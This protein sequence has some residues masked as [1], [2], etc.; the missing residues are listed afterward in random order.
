MIFNAVGAVLSIFFMI[1]IGIFVYWRK[2][3]NRKEASVFAK[4]VI[5]VALPANVIYSFLTKFNK[6]LIL[7][8]GIYLLV[9]VI[10]LIIT[11]L[12]GYGISVLLKVDKSR[13]GIFSVLFASSNSVF[14]GFPVAQALFGDAG[15]LYAFLFY[16]VNTTM[17]WTLGYAGIRRDGELKK[18]TADKMSFLDILKKLINIP[19]ISLVIGAVLMLIDI[20]LPVN[21]MSTLKYIAGLTIPLSLIFTGIVLADIGLKNLKFERDILKV[22]LGRFLIAPLIMFLVISA[23]GISGLGKQVFIVQMSLPVLLQSTIMAQYY[24]ADVDFATK[25]FAWTTIASLAIIPFYMML[26][27]FVF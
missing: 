6:S 4:I 13:R 25:S 18:G 14:I 5:N 19:L 3:I 1:G 26:V 24:N 15:M 21:V 7:S 27:N 17:F 12:I 23:F 8:S 9:G 20:K 16:I 10:A 22:F 11:Y 2:W